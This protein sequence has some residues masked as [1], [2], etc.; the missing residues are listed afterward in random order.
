M[1]VPA[2]CSSPSTIAHLDAA[3]NVGTAWTAGTTGTVG[4]SG[5][6]GIAGTV[7][8][9]EMFTL[10]AQLTLRHYWQW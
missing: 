4:T 8:N 1:S 3:V 2:I 9:L 5:T 6:F 7:D 10:L